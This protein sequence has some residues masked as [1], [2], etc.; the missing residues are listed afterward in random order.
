M[1]SK[2]SLTRLVNAAT[3][4]SGAR[5][6]RPAA[7]NDSRRA[8]QRGVTAACGNRMADH[9]RA[10]IVGWRRAQARPARRPSRRASS[11]PLLARSVHRARRP[12][13]ARSRCA[14]AGAPRR[15]P[16]AAAKGVTSRNARQS[17]REAGAPSAVRSPADRSRD[18]SV[19][20]RCATEGANPSSRSAVTA[21]PTP[22]V[23]G[24]RRGGLGRQVRGTRDVAGEPMR[25]GHRC[26]RLGR[27]KAVQQHRFLGLGRRATS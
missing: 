25:G 23:C 2:L 1:G 8:D 27:A 16:S 15:R 11:R 6:P 12:G 17:A 10:G 5:I 7:R 19:R 20:R 18:S 22:A 3:V 9:G 4:A 21:P 26:D 13:W 14:R 24:R